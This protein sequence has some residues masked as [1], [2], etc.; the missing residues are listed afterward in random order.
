MSERKIEYFQE[1]FKQSP[2]Y[3][4]AKEYQIK[5]LEKLFSLSDI[6]NLMGMD[7]A[8]VGGDGNFAIAKTLAYMS[9]RPVAIYNPA[10]N[11]NSSE[12]DES[13]KPV[14]KPF[15]EAA[16]KPGTLDLIYGCA[17]LEHIGNLPKFIAKCHEYLKSGGGLLLQ[18]GPMWNSPWGHHL[19]VKTGTWNYTFDGNNIVPD[20][21]HWLYS[22]PELE[23][24]LAKKGIPEEACRLIGEQI[25]ESDMLNRV[26]TDELLALF[27]DTEWEL[28]IEEKE[29]GIPKAVSDKGVLG[30]RKAVPNI[31]IYARKKSAVGPDGYA[32]LTNAVV[33]GSIAGQASSSASPTTHDGIFRQGA[34]DMLLGSALAVNWVLT[35]MCNYQ[36]S[37]CFGQEKLDRRRF[38]PL[39]DLKYAVDILATQNRPMYDIVFSGGEPTTHPHF[40]DIVQYCAERLDERLNYIQIISNGSRNGKL[41]DRLAQISADIPLN[42]LISLH[43]EYV[44]LAH[45]ISIIANLSRS[46]GLSFNLM[47]NPER[48]EKTVELHKTLSAIRSYFPFGMQITLLRAGKDYSVIDSRYVKEDFAWVD[49]ANAEFKKIENNSGM[50]QRWQARSHHNL[51][52]DTLINGQLNHEEFSQYN[53]GDFLRF[54]KLNFDGIQCPVGTSMLAINPDGRVRGAQCS[55]APLHYNIF[56]EDPW[57]KN[58]F[59]KLVKCPFPNCGCGANDVIPKFADIDE[60][61]A[62]IGQF[63]RKAAENGCP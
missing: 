16:I 28:S 2:H 20:W 44:D 41:Y 46:A 45:I 62:F 40:F 18:G 56:R 19:Y 37:Y 51:Y 54:G 32:A 27:S 60:A 39:K 50:P 43:T 59:L 9:G 31:Y 4:C 42:L 23:S 21:A 6:E 29:N 13:I 34:S 53:R 61:K 52:W 5:T 55:A 63:A 3:V 1:L 8:E 35:L 58:D 38:S 47:F 33:S 48:R 7:I 10:L 24:L 15:E 22:R 36:C 11:E 12:I 25:Y 14:N 49:K 57:E 17:V 30:N 26:S